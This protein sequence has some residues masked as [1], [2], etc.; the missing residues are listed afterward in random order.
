MQKLWIDPNAIYLAKPIN[1]RPINQGFIESLRESM[2][3][4]GFL[5][6]YPVKVFAAEVLTCVETDQPFACVS[7]MHRTTAAQLAKI[8]E[9]LCEVHTG[10][11]DA[12]IEMMMTDNF[13]YD[14]ARNSEL[15]QIFSKTEKRKACQRLLYIPKFLRMTNRALAEEWHTNEANIR[16]W[17]KEVA[18]SFDAPRN[19]GQAADFVPETLRRVGITAERLQELKEINDSRERED[20]KGN[21]VQIRPAP[22]EMSDDEK[23]EFWS[24]IRNDAGRHNDGWLKEHGIKDFDHVR[25]YLSKKYNIEGSYHMDEDLTTQQLRQLHR[26]ILSDDPELIAGCKEIAD[27]HAVIDSLRDELREVCGA[28]KKWLLSEF[29]QGNEYSQA[30]KDCKAA[31]TEAARQA[32][33]ADYCVEYYDFPGGENLAEKFKSYLEL[34]DAV[35]RDVATVLDSEDPATEVIWVRQFCQQME[36]DTLAKRQ[37]L[38]KNWIK[39][40]QALADALVA[41]PRNIAPTAFCLAMDDEFYEK[42]GTHFKLFSRTEISSRVHNDTLKDQIRHFKQATKDLAED[43]KWVRAIAEEPE[44]LEASEPTPSIE[45]VL[46]DGKVLGIKLICSNNRHYWFEDNSLTPGAVPLSSV[47]EEILVNLLMLIK[48]VE[49]LDTA[50]ADFLRTFDELRL[51]DDAMLYTLAQA[52]TYYSC[53]L[54]DLLMLTYLFPHRFDDEAA[55]NYRERMTAPQINAWIN[56]LESMKRDM[57][58]RENWMSNVA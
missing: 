32:G 14:P 1:P 52:C 15:G 19:D 50:I 11:D 20:V 35:Q 54:Q 2:E 3:V 5:P 56:T 57:E 21:T 55:K 36:K 30:Y 58:T 4:Q 42:S 12:F 40:K 41:Y 45:D 44:A 33:H 8:D 13:E 49:R 6:Q 39:A 37:K 47:P 25:K 48:D 27:E 10:D 38:E 22:K 26:D 31:F 53:I 28:I 24:Q 18:A 46:P 43:A 23:S 34:V 7:G 17:R 16:R 51:S 9:I 29:V